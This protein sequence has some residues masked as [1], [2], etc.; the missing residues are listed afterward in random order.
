MARR[1]ASTDVYD[2][3]L[4]VEPL[5]I[6]RLAIGPGGYEPGRTNCF[7]VYFIESGSGAVAVD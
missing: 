7:R 1:S 4:G 2:P 6:R 5:R 3:R